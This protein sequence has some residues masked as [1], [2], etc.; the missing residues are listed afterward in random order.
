MVESHGT[1]PVGNV[2]ASG[3]RWTQEEAIAFEVAK[4][5]IGH[6]LTVYSGEIADEEKKPAPSAERLDRLEAEVSRLSRERASFHV[7]DHVEVER[8]TAHYG[9][10]VR[11]YND[12][13]VFQAA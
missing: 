3:P 6:W 2:P 8:V 1:R 5:C 9:A 12:S 10:L 4:E 7:Q 13:G 11:A